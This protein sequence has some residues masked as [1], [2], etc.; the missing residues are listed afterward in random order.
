M[1][2]PDRPAR[3]RQP[4]LRARVL[5]PVARAGTRAAGAALRPLNDAAGAAFTAGLNAERRAVELVL[6]S[7]ELERIVTAALDNPRLREKVR[8]ACDSEAAQ[9]LIDG[10]FDSGLFDRIAERLLASDGLWHLIDE[11]A[12]SPAVTAAISQQGLSFADQI[13]DE[14]RS[15]S[16]SADDWLERAAHRVVR[17]R[18][19]RAAVQ[20]TPAAQASP[21]TQ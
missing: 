8:Q 13:G 5:R 11:I 1:D 12:A 16:R 20:A 17:A 2:G 6:D 10:F 9:R 18:E 19:R 3:A 14:V 4:Q 21:P 7:Q 15:R